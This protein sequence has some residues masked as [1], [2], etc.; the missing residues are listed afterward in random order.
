MDWLAALTTVA[1]WGG[2]GAG[3]DFWIGKKGQKGVVSKLEHRDQT[4]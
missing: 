3:I 4:S 2:I 1:A